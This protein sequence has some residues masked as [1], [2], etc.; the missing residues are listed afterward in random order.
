MMRRL[1][2]IAYII[3]VIVGLFFI[4]HSGTNMSF[5]VFFINSFIFILI[6]IRGRIK[7]DEKEIYS[8]KQSRRIKNKPYISDEEYIAICR[9]YSTFYIVSGGVWGLYAIIML[10]RLASQSFNNIDL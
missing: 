1:I 6:G 5:I 2:L 8:M 3:L 4:W 7:P 9:K 10:I